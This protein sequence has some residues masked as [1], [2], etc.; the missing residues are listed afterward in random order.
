MTL[1]ICGIFSSVYGLI[2]IGNFSFV[3][4]RFLMAKKFIINLHLVYFD[5]FSYSTLLNTSRWLLANITKFSNKFN[6]LFKN[7]HSKNYKFFLFTGY[8]K[9]LTVS[10]DISIQKWNQTGGLTTDLYIMNLLYYLDKQWN[11]AGVMNDW[12]LL[13]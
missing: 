2:N 6:W 11:Q 9:A 5:I 7:I 3:M 13:S 8:W 1:S 4:F 10:V 12:H